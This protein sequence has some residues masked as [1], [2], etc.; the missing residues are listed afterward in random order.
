M[1]FL[2]I[3]QEHALELKKHFDDPEIQDALMQ[4][5]KNQEGSLRWTME[6]QV[7]Q[8][9]LWAPDVEV[10]DSDDEREGSDYEVVQKDDEME[11]DDYDVVES[12]EVE[13]CEGATD[14]DAA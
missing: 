11:D 9:N 7:N 2:Q 5:I 6:A 12:D 3:V 8:H 14:E 10:E 13:N 1:A 4:R